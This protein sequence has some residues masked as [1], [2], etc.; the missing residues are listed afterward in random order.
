MEW[1]GIIIKKKSRLYNNTDRVKLG[2]SNISW[3]VVL[4]PHP[5]YTCSV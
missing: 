4:E 3:G 1:N 2:S 5:Y